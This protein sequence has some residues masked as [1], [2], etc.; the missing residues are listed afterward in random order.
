MLEDHQVALTF[1][2]VIIRKTQTHPV[3]RRKP[4]VALSNLSRFRRAHK[5]IMQTISGYRRQFAGA[6]TTFAH[7]FRQPG[8]ALG[9]EALC[10]HLLPQVKHSA[11]GLIR[12]SA[13]QRGPRFQIHPGRVAVLQRARG[14][15]TILEP[16]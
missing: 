2:I 15:K 4:R 9:A 3:V 13:K 5:F 11:H 12:V 1:R 6:I 14:V 7:K 10:S 8:S 16:P